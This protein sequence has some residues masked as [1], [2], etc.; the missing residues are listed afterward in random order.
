MLRDIQETAL[1]NIEVEEQT[2][3]IGIIGATGKLGT[4]VL[5]EAQQRGHEVTA[6]VRNAAKLDAAKD[7]K[8]IEK[9]V[10]DL[11]SDD[12]KDLDVVVNAFGAPLGEEE[13]YVEVRRILINILKD[14]DTRAI[15][16]G[17]D[18]SLFADDAHTIRVMD[19][20]DFPEIVKP[21]AKGSSRNLQDLQHAE[22]ITWTFIS[23]SAEFDFE[24]KRTGTYTLGKDQL[25]FNSKGNSY[26]SYADF[27]IAIVDEAENKAHINER[28]TVVGEEE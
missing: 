17:G 5:D 2:M 14:V 19:T 1:I 25:L 18:G 7:V 12:I 20:P 10:F 6:I 3:N 27:A 28:F 22:G 13:V 4:K 15:I 16:V 24:G 9:D 11:T 21:T 23:P 8:V 26:I